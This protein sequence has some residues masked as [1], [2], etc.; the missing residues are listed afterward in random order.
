MHAEGGGREGGGG[1]WGVTR[2]RL[3][4]KLG[5]PP[6]EP[7]RRGPGMEGRPLVKPLPRSDRDGGE[8]GCLGPPIY[9]GTLDSMSSAE[10][11]PDVIA[12]LEALAP[13]CFC[14]ALERV[15]QSVSACSRL[16]SVRRLF[17]EVPL[18]DRHCCQ[19]FIAFRLLDDSA[20]AAAKSEDHRTASATAVVRALPRLF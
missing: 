6:A 8:S 4:P 11:P 20:L 14:L 17:R 9:W 10:R 1:G 12:P 2:L 3:P 7:D 18:N 16:L 19:Q 15:P 5:K 13:R